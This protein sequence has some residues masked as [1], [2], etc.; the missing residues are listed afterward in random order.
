MSIYILSKDYILLKSAAIW[1]V[2]VS[3]I[4]YACKVLLTKCILA[5]ETL[6]T[7]SLFFNFILICVSLFQIYNYRV[8]GDFEYG[9]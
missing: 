8:K 7:D 3:Q 2:R 6:F 5:L 1:S 9:R 4:S